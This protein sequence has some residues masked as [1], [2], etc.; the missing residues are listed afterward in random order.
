MTDP[1]G[2]WLRIGGV[3]VT[4]SCVDWLRIGCVTSIYPV[5]IVRVNEGRYE[6]DYAGQ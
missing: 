5:G 4:D 2:D 1:R 3:K 6:K